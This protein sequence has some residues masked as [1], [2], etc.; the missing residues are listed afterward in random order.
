M[1]R[2]KTRRARRAADGALRG[3]RMRELDRLIAR[4]NVAATV[5]RALGTSVCTVPSCM[6]II[7]AC[8]LCKRHYV[9]WWK[10]GDP[11]G[12][13]SGRAGIAAIKTWDRRRQAAVTG[14]IEA[15]VRPAL[16][17]DN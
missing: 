14:G 15:G 4:E 16:S 10:Y 13:A 17:P 1:G 6:G 9:R 12:R 2:M 8:G 7:S 3:D 11:L 5:E